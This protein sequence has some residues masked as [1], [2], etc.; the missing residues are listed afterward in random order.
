MKRGFWVVL[1]LVGAVPAVALAQEAQPAEPGQARVPEEVSNEALQQQIQ[2]LWQGFRMLQQ[3]VAE[4]RQQQQ[5]A[6]PGVA[7][8]GTAGA[9]G[10]AGQAGTAR[11][12]E[13]GTAGAV[14]GAGQAGT[15][16]AEQESLIIVELPEPQEQ[17]GRSVDRR[18]DQRRRAAGVGGSGA[19]R[20]EVTAGQDVYE[21]TVRSVSGDRLLLVAQSGRV[22]EL[23]VSDQTCVI[24]QEGRRQSLRALEEGTPVRAVAEE[25]EERDQVLTLHILEQRRSR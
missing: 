1:G 20:A 7:G 3:E 21:G 23:G 10:G 15:A 24:G 17:R 4:L 22:Y 14:G 5:P 18:A 12:G 8:S 11:G 6:R 2:E 9:V 19:A 16:G 25:G 13:A